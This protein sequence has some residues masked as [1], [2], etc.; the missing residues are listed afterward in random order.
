MRQSILLMLAFVCPSFCLPGAA[1]LNKTQ[2]DHLL[3]QQITVNYQNVTL[4]YI[5]HDLSDRYRIKFAYLNNE[6]SE[7][8][9][10]SI[11]ANRQPLGRVLDELFQDTNLAYE[12]VNGQIVLK[13]R[14]DKSSS[15]ALPD[16]ARSTKAQGGANLPP[17]SSAKLASLPDK[18]KSMGNTSF[19]LPPKVVITNRP[20]E[21]VKNAHIPTLPDH[22]EGITASSPPPKA[23]IDSREPKESRSVEKNLVRMCA[24]PSTN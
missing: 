12:V 4:S 19:K 5:L 8:Q 2:P 18:P 17:S 9:T 14:I 20:E 11:Q 22:L 15:L 16:A 24:I 23:D 7:K 1:L 6:I 3:Q 10:F 13:R 21:S